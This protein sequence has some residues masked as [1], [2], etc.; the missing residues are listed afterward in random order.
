MEAGIDLD[1]IGH[2]SPNDCLKEWRRNA[3]IYPNYKDLKTANEKI[4]YLEAENAL[5]KKLEALE[6]LYR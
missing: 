1:A 4:Q 2:D 6:N 3:K 5:L